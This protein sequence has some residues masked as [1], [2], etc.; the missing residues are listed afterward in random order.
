MTWSGDF[1][2]RV[3]LGEQ[4]YRV[5]F[6]SIYDGILVVSAETYRFIDANPRMCTMF[7]YSHAEMVELD[8]GH[9]SMGPPPAILVDRASF[10]ERT[11]FG[12]AVVFE[13]SCTGK[14]G[15]Q[16]WTEVAARRADFDGDDIVL[17]TLRDTTVRRTAQDGLAYRDRILAAVTLSVAEL[18]NSPSMDATMAKVLAAVGEALNVDRILVAE[19]SHLNLT[20]PGAVRYAWRKPDSSIRLIESVE[21]PEAKAGEIEN[22]LAPLLAGNP[23]ISSAN[24]ATGFVAQMMRNLGS[25]STIQLP[26]TVAGSYWGHVIIDD[27]KQ[28]RTW[29]AVEINALGIFARV[30]G[31][32]LSRERA[33]AQLEQMARYDE[34]TGLPNRRLFCQILEKE[35]A[36][37]G[38][39]GR[40]FGVLLLNLDR[41][42]DMDDTLGRAIGDDL[43]KLVA[44]R[45]SATVH[46]VDTIARFGA[47]DFAALEV[48]VR[49][50]SDVAVFADEL[51]DVLSEP[52]FVDG[53]QVR[54]NASVGVSLFGANSPDAETLLAHAHVALYRA[55]ADGGKRYRFFTTSMESDLR[56]R[57]AL[58]KALSAAV[59][60][61]EFFVEYQPQVDT[62][63]NEIVGLEALVRW[64]HPT[65]GTV[66]PG[67]FIPAA[68][69]TGLIVPI[70]SF[71][72]REA[73]LQVKR[74]L[75]AGINPPVV[76]VNVSVVQ[77]K[78]SRAFTTVLATTLAE[79]GVEAGRIEIELTE[80]VIMEAAS[81]FGDALLGLRQMGC[82]I[83]IDDFGNGYSSLDYLRRFHVDRIKIP[84]N[85]TTELCTQP[86]DAMIVLSSLR[87]AHQLGMDVIIEGV[88]TAEQVAYLRSAGCRFVQGF[89]YSKPLAPDEATAL[90][91]IGHVIPKSLIPLAL[92]P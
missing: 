62:T 20:L 83:A 25:I 61:N 56:A 74:W 41:F 10:R 12:E 78:A 23:V 42:K 57:V 89:Y 29:T 70:G 33:R 35:I 16:F 38:R 8:F 51:V 47:D 90:L 2:R 26:V 77:F 50:A 79:T 30:I 91:R 52:Y 17:L 86:N 75:E 69:K 55:K 19:G 36:R 13:W 27:C 87:L 15:G 24:T 48:D 4:R 54:V 72:L 49:D 68:E 73:C 67:E 14:H 9:L 40:T 85:F 34:L 82:R 45:L 71:V 18:V 64:R 60:A 11:T 22:W 84:Q 81:G 39:S 6:D 92:A 44:E 28:L 37:V 43:L 21:H 1:E 88:E 59:A 3:R 76:A 63:T 31:A 66:S 58:E 5:I 80:S 53:N 32:V 65:R 7:G 46:A